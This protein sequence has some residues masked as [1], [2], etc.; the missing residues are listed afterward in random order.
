MALD[1]NVIQQGINDQP[2]RLVKDERRFR[3]FTNVVFGKAVPYGGNTAQDYL[4]LDSEFRSAGL[5]EEAEKGLD[6]H[7][8]NYNNPFKSDAV[9]G[10]YYNDEDFVDSN[11]ARERLVGES[12]SNPMSQDARLLALLGMKSD[13]LFDTYGNSLE[14]KLANLALTGK[15]MTRNGGENVFPVVSGLLSM[16]GSKLISDPIACLGA[17]MTT[18][19]K[20]GGLMPKMLVLNPSDGIKLM[21]SSKMQE[22]MDKRRIESGQVKY[23]AIDEN[24]LSSLGY[25][26]VAGV[27]YLDVY[28]YYGAYQEGSSYNYLIPQG[29]ALL[30]PI[31]GIGF[32][33]HCGVF[34][35]KEYASPKIAAEHYKYVYS[36]EGPL[37]HKTYVQL[38]YAPCP[39]I[40]ELTSYGVLKD[41]PTT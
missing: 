12:I 3:F 36:P 17:A 5:T 29:K 13:R 11:M 1:I 39:V 35:G 28:S 41:I 18:F 27:G 8:V 14:K 7:R 9:A 21:T 4:R 15:I 23:G 34:A 24:G 6:P 20:K 19:A 33:G 31:G 16:D 25:V 26:D 2:I 22:V 32:I 40:T 30:L 10:L 37:P 38:Q